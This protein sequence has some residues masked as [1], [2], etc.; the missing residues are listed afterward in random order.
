MSHI[1][2]FEDYRDFLRDQI[3]RAVPIAGAKGR[4]AR[5]AGC[6]P[7][8]VSRVLGSEVHLT[9]EQAAGLAH[10]WRLSSGET[11]YFLELL[12]FA[13]AGTPVLRQVIQ[14][15]LGHLR[16]E[17]E[18]LSARLKVTS[19]SGE[20]LRA[21]YY[22]AWY[23]AAIHVLVSI[24]GFDSAE[25]IARHLSLPEPVVQDTMERLKAALLLENKKGRWY[26]GPSQIHM[27]RESPYAGWHHANW[28]FRA[29]IDRDKDSAI[30]YTG[31]HSLS[32]KDAALIRNRLLSMLEENS[33]RVRD[34]KEEALFCL[35]LDYFET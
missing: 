17:H 26:V 15:R 4:L 13:R 12:Y 5:A 35:N 20:E 8:Y 7:S 6:S 27:G 22:S 33:Q 25:R 29:L 9:P 11:E 16:Q 10:H 19:L 3:S 28:R 32:R 1:F 31:L 34:S 14:R 18:S 23:V 30:H 21:F 2:Q 24:P